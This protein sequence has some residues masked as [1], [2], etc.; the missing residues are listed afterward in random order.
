MNKESPVVFVGFFFQEKEFII[1]MQNNASKQ[2]H[3]ATCGA[4]NQN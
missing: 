2:C 4:M 3:N 1:S